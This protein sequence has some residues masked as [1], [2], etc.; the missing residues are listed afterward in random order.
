MRVKLFLIS[1][2]IVSIIFMAEILLMIHEYNKYKESMIT[3]NILNVCNI[4]ANFIHLIDVV[5]SITIYIIL[6]LYLI[7]IAL[8][9]SL[10]VVQDS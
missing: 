3:S 10:Y 1:I 5:F 2:I 4:E 8:L 7:M 6:L 9:T